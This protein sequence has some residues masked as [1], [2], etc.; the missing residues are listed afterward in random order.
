MNATERECISEIRNAVV[1]MGAEIKLCA[2]GK[3]SETQTLI[4]I[5]KQ[6]VRAESQLKILQKSE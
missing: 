1:A 3:R 5:V 4:E 2:K 6:L